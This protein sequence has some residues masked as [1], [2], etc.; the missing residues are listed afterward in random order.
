MPTFLRYILGFI[1]CGLLFSLTVRLLL[2]F[3][4]QLMVGLFSIIL[5][6]FLIQAMRII[7]KLTTGAPVGSIIEDLNRILPGGMQITPRG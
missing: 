7:W 1:A 3:L 5:I 2:V 4:P 6:L